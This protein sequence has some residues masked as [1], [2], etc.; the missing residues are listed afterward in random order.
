MFLR[1]SYFLANLRLNVLINM[2]LTQKKECMQDQRTDLES[3]NQIPWHATKS[4]F[5]SN[6][7]MTFPVITNPVRN[8]FAFV[9]KIDIVLLRKKS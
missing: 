3:D 9:T 8:T 7:C 5:L 1:C 6:Y 4:F 2:V